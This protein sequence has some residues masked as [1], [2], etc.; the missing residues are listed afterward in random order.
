LDSSRPNEE[1]EG[2]LSVENLLIIGFLEAP[3]VSWNCVTN[4]HDC[5][6]LCF[7]GSLTQPAVAADVF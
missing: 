6:F 1:E 2:V 7:R 4:T 3:H 5:F